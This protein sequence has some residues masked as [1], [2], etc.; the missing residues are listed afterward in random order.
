MS[1][2]LD[3]RLSTRVDTEI[4]TMFFIYINGSRGQDGVTE[5]TSMFSIYINQEKLHC[6]IW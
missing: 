3:K 1:L 2:I 5:V 4:C 6:K